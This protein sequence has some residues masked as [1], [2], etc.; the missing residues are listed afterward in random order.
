VTNPG[1]Y[2]C[3]PLVLWFFNFDSR[4]PRPC[5][6]DQLGKP[7]A[8]PDPRESRGVKSIGPG[9]LGGDL[10]MVIYWEFN[11]GYRDFIRFI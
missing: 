2:I 3:G 9:R 6:E 11:I 8:I 7:G 4:Y 10:K 5:S 1:L